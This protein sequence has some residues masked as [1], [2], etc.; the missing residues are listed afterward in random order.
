[1]RDEGVPAL[2]L[3]AGNVFFKREVLKQK[4]IDPSRLTADLIVSAYN[5]MGCDV[6]NVGGYDLSLGIDY[7][8]QKEAQSNSTYISANL[9]SRHGKRLFKPYVIKAVG[10][11]RI[12]IFGLIDG[13][14][15]LDKIPSGHKIVA[16]D[17]YEASR[18]AVAELKEEHGVDFVVLL[19]DMMDRSLRRMALLGLP[20]DLIIGSDKRN[21]I[22]LPIVVGN[23]YIT[24][25]DRGGKSVGRADI[26]RRSV[27]QAE[28]RVE[29]QSRRG[30]RIGDW[31]L[32]HR[33]VQLR[34]SFP[35]HP[36]VGRMVDEVTKRISAAQQDLMTQSDD[37]SESDCGKRYVGVDTCADC[38]A[39]RHK[40]WLATGHARAYEALVKKNRQFDEACV[41]CHALAYEC[42]K[43][44][45][46]LK[47]VEA[48]SNVQCESCHGPGDLHVQSRG[49]QPMIVERETQR[50]CLRCH[51]P[52]R[53]SVSDFGTRIRGIC[54]DL[55]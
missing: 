36:T 9:F 28:H 29:A 26:H 27:A 6:F 2:F 44:S 19:T 18:G 45:L 46:D 40:T 47:S 38:H 48:F 5:V 24:H 34:L 7:L 23:S 17:P 15:K 51:T 30:T 41:V 11:V 1:V 20:I 32:R 22:A 31:S 55:E 8:L 49:E 14:L 33:F 16:Q 39:G 4:Q 43:E 54:S 13:R 35:D 37:G 50:S 52:E 21:K 53:S 3:N 42:D 25:L 12:G 10:G